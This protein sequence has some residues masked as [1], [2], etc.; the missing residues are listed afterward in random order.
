MCLIFLPFSSPA[1]LIYRPGEG[2]TY[3]AVGSEGKWQRARAKEQLEVAQAAFDSKNYGTA[4]KAARRV[5]RVWPLSDY[6]PKAR[7]LVGRCYEAKG[8]DEKAFKEFDKL[9]TKSPKLDNYDEI[10]Q[11]EFEIAG[12]YL[13]GKRFRLWGT[14]P[15]YR[16]MDR[17]A[18]MYDKI[19][20][21]GPFSD[22]APQAQLKIGAAREKQ[23]NYAMAVKAYE[24]A[25]DR[26]HDRPKVASEALYRQALAY[27]KQAMTAE[28]DQT[29]AGQAIA[30]FTDFQTLYPDDTR[31][32]E[33]QKIING[34]KSEQARGS[35]QTAKFYEKYKKWK[36][37]VVYYNEVTLQ[38]PTSQYANIAK[39]RIDAL[40]KRTA[41]T[42]P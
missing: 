41:G 12:K 26:Y 34:L 38:D 19:V 9:V 32:S 1:P 7:Y 25:A 28:Y 31:S 24:L 11:R 22:V 20:K 35:F 14:I 8:K 17:T 5:V 18:E 27:N 23:K 33:A 29:A 16:S 37:A 13:A 40:Q 30:T 21:S 15:L 2:W 3:E 4:L 42:S 36:G 10:V 39:D 6:A